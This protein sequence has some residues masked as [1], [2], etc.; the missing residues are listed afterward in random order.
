MAGV[1]GVEGRPVVV[2]EGAPHRIV[3]ADR[4]RVGDPQLPH[5]PAD[6]VEVV[7]DVELGGV[8]ADDDQPVVLVLLGP[9]ADIG[10]LA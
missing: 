6:V 9:G 3:V 1:G 5:G 7:L 4:D 8:H 10:K 2:V